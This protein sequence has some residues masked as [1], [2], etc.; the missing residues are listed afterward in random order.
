MTN[1]NFKPVSYHIIVG[2]RSREALQLKEA[3]PGRPVKSRSSV[4][5]QPHVDFFHTRFCISAQPHVGG[6]L[7]H[8]ILYFCPITCVFLP[9]CIL[10]F[11]PFTYMDFFHSRFGISAQPHVDFLNIA[12]YI[13]GL[14]H[15]DFSTLN[16]VFLPNH[17]AIT[18]LPHCTTQFDLFQTRLKVHFLKCV[19]STYVDFFHIK[20]CISL[21]FTAQQ[22]VDLVVGFCVSQFFSSKNHDKSVSL[23]DRAN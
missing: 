6:L 23:C 7:P 5:A 4:P 19:I 20:I 12:Y 9:H 16:F 3:D 18:P 22:H 8:W 1:N 13:F 11:C 17:S 10:Y 2:D 21:S 14:P 15:L